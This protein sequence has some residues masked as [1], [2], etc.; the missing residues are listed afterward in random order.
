MSEFQFEQPTEQDNNENKSR[1]TKTRTLLKKLCL[2]FQ[3]EKYL[4]LNR[5]RQWFDLCK[6]QKHATSKW[7]TF[8]LNSRPNKTIMKY[9]LKNRNKNFV[10]KTMFSISEWKKIDLNING[11]RFDLWKPQIHATSEW[12]SFNLNSRP[13]KTIMKA[14]L[15][16]RKKEL[17]WRNSELDKSGVIQRIVTISG[18]H[19]SA[20][21]AA[22]APTTR[23]NQRERVEKIRPSVAGVSPAQTIVQLC[24]LLTF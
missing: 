18:G 20:F 12:A 11:Q 19:S 1:K 14:N 5:N 7:E 22:P 21:P 3:N 23:K 4:N 2:V 17:C 8:N 6:P 10:G 9:I 15:E 13:N 16:K 24:V